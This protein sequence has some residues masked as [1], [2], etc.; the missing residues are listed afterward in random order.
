MWVLARRVRAHYYAFEV[1]AAII[2]L[3]ANVGYAAVFALI[4][5]EAISTIGPAAAILGVAA[6][7]WRHRRAP[8]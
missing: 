2:D 3:P 7:V 1:L 5:E 8:A 4:A 6:L